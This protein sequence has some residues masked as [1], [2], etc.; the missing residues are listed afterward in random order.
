[1]V[2]RGDFLIDVNKRITNDK[3]AFANVEGDLEIENVDLNESVEKIY[4]F[5]KEHQ[6]AA[7]RAIHARWDNFE[8]CLSC[9]YSHID[10]GALYC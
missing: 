6:A 2:R 5:F 9:E 4:A 1:M 3:I 7:C 10:D 8:D